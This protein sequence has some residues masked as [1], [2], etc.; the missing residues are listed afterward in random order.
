MEE[1]YLGVTEVALSKSPFA[2]Y[3]TKD[4]SLQYIVAYGGIDGAHHKSWVLDQVARI[5]NGTPVKVLRAEWGPSKDY[6]D[7]LVE[8]RYV[9]GE[10][11]AE[12]LKM[13]KDAK[14]D[15]KSDDP[16]GYTWDEGIEP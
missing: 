6:P 8:W 4:W 10:P 12:Y 9:T 13:V 3:T 15:P 14:Y 11:S 16:E 7:G 5:L 2:T 1:N